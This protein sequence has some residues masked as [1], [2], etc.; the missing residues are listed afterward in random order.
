MVVRIGTFIPFEAS[1]HL[2][3][4]HFIER[5]LI[6]AG[7]DFRK[8]DNAFLSTADRSFCKLPPTVSLRK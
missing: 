7:V 4:R 8:D 6:A 2:N 3:G 5:Q 1:Y